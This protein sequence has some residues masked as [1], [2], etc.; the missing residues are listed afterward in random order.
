ML[1]RSDLKESV[2]NRV[3]ALKT[4]IP[5]AFTEMKN[6]VV[7][8]VTEIWSSVTEKFTAIR[9]GIKEKIHGA[10]DAVKSAIDKIKSFFKFSWS[11]PKLKL[12][13]LSITG[14]FS[15]AP[16]RVP[17]FG[18]SWYKDGAIFSKPTLFNTP[19]GT[20]GVGEAG[21]EAVLP[22]EKLPDILGFDAFERMIYLLEIIASKNLSI[23]SKV[24]ADVAGPDISRWLALEGHR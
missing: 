1:F 3:T 14:S 18:I 24:L 16:P 8:R 9:N 5:Q 2:V 12:P 20:K 11:L 15:I 19:Y 10:R 4:E 6:N 23:N 22:I 7:N 21:A 17:K 13:H